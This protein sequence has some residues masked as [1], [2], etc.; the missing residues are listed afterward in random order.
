M[1][2]SILDMIKMLTERN[3]FFQNSIKDRMTHFIISVIDMIE[4]CKI[5]NERIIFTDREM[6]NG[7]I[8]ISKH[9]MLNERIM[10]NKSILL[11]VE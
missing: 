10:K 2:L 9:T 5:I 1:F 6:T 8:M 4:E 7:R 11:N 3:F